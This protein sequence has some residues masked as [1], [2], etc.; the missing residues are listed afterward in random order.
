MEHQVAAERRMLDVG[1]QQQPRGADAVAGD[2][3]A[4]GGLHD[5][6]ALGVAVAHAGRGAGLDL[7]LLHDG[8]RS[9]LD[10][11]GDRL[12]EI[13][14]VGRRLRRGRA[15]LQ[16]RAAVIAGRAAVI[17]GRVDRRVDRPPVPAEPVEAAR[18]RHAHAAEPQGRHGARGLRRIGRIAGEPRDADLDVVGIV[19]RLEFEIVER[20]VVA[21]AIERARLEVGRMQARKMRR[22]VD[23]RAADAVPHQRLERRPRV[24]DRI[25][26][27][28]RRAARL[29][30][31]VGRGSPGAEPGALP[32]APERRHGSTVDP[33]AAL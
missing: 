29:Q 30:P 1:S 31:Q 5:I 2:D 17:G 11:G 19:E 24:V 32:V 10:A 33:V 16:A 28:C 21:D 9:E 25:V 27:R 15:A 3:D 4:G 6:V 26:G 18:R 23:G 22:P 7:D 13:G 14:P 20:P 8:A 12:G